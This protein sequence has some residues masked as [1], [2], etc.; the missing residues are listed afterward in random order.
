MTPAARVGAAIELVAEIEKSI[1]GAGAAADALVRSFFK[2]RRYAGSKDRAA[3]SDLVYAVLRRR[4]LLTWR[5]GQAGC[6]GSPRLLVL[7]A[8]AVPGPGQEQGREP[9]PERLFGQGPYAAPELD[10]GELAALGALREASPAAPP[11]WVAGEYPEWLAGELSDRFGDS[12]AAE[13][14]AL[15][16]RAAVDVRVNTLKAAREEALGKLAEAGFE[17]ELCTLSPVGLRLVERRQIMASKPFR[18]GLVEVQDEGSQIAALLVAARPGM[19][20]CDLCA[21][22]GGKTLALAAAMENK[23]QILAVERNAGRRRRMKTRLT[24]A[25]V[26]NVQIMDKAPPELAGRADRVLVDAP[27]TGSGTWRRSPDARWRLDADML[28]RHT[29]RQGALLDRGAALVAPGGRLVYVTCSLLPAENEAPVAAFLD[30]Q[31]EFSAVPAAAAWRGALDEAPPEGADLGDFILL[32]PARHGT[33]GFVI[34][35]LERRK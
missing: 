25:A 18:G 19:Q 8:L 27:C 32:T 24:R 21:G 33:D 2:N 15:T 5:L 29:V 26:R 20:V 30:R 22:A 1:A 12:L 3:V 11:E 6:E 23:G 16:E 17:A 13:A 31:P 28:A 34:A 14:A 4:A 10:A 9:A 7:A 35:V